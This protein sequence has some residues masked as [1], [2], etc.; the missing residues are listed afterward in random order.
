[1][2]ATYE[3]IATTTLG[4][5]AASITFSSIPA[6]YTDLKVILTGFIEYTSP[7]RSFLYMRFNGDT[8]TNYSATYIKGDGTTAS[9]SQD[10]S[11]DKARIGYISWSPAGSGAYYSLN[12]IDIFSYAGSTYKTALGRGNVDMNT[13]A[14]GEVHRNVIL[15]RSTSAITSVNLYSS[16]TRNFGT[17]TTATL[18]GIK[19][20]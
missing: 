1:M 5:A 8:A 9:S 15:W 13:A 16:L 3:P 2:P 7:D 10:T 4:S 20:A 14:T 6:T 12:E 17:G 11:S 18:Y 19:N